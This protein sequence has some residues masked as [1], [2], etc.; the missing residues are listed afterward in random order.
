[1]A[2]EFATGA[3]RSLI[4]KLGELLLDEYNLKGT[5]KKGIRDLKAELETM[6]AALEK[7]SNVPLD[8][9]NSQVKIWAN[10]VRSYPMP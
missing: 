1:M 2:I 3:M 4:P 6:Q 10:E 7:V 8:Q 5:V 9:L